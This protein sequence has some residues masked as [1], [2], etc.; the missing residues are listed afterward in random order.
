M[1]NRRSLPANCDP[2]SPD[3]EMLAMLRATDAQW[4]SLERVI[5]GADRLLALGL[6]GDEAVTFRIKTH[7]GREQTG[8]IDKAEAK[9]Q[10]EP[11]AATA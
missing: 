7:D 1:K 4:A 6:D 8:T 3:I 5:N 9:I 2:A 10:R 11:A